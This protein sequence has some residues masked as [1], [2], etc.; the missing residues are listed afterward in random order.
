MGKH[1]EQT[2]PSVYAYHLTGKVGKKTTTNKQTLANLKD[3]IL[4]VFKVS[5]LLLP[6]LIPL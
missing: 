6:L 1:L 4:E 2:M 5:H 3:H